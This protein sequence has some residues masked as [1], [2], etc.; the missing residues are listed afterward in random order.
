[1]TIFRSRNSILLD[2]VPRRE[3]HRD[4]RRGRPRQR[5]LGVGAE[6]RGAR[7]GSQVVGQRRRLRLLQH[8]LRR[9]AGRAGLLGCVRERNMND[10]DVHD[11]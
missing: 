3:V 7:A 10:H 8:E 9:R 1:M 4:R 2:Q 11:Q 6:G 5:V